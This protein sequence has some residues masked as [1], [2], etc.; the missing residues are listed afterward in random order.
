MRCACVTSL[1]RTMPKLEL[2][3]Y[4]ISAPVT[5]SLP[6]SSIVILESLAAAQEKRRGNENTMQESA[7]D[8]GSPRKD[9]E[10]S[11]SSRC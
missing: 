9:I 7:A 6:E 11:V 3:R 8:G 10:K 1:C 4:W 2:G 5:G